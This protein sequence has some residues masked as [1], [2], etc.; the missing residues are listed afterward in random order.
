M[1]SMKAVVILSLTALMIVPAQAQLFSREGVGGALLG[2]L[3]GGIIGHNSGGRTAEGV[4]IGAGSGLILGGLL[5]DARTQ[6]GY[7]NT[8]VPYPSAG[9]SYYGSPA[10]SYGSYPYGSS[11]Y[12]PSWGRPNYAITGAA[13]GGVAGGII[14][15][16][17]RGRTAEGVGIGA[18]AGLLLGGLAEYQ[19]RRNDTYRY[20]SPMYTPT[21]YVTP[22]AGYFTP[23]L[24]TLPATTAPSTPAP[25]QITI[26]NNYYGSSSPMSGAN[27]LFGR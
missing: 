12:S 2:G 14:G 16:N 8:Q 4:A 11:Y 17:S 19:A 24:Q 7:Y 3:A 5:H 26:I 13:L 21:A 25:Q 18:G 27:S 1:K 15:H 23:S 9:Y 6:S 22:S 20:A 10:Y